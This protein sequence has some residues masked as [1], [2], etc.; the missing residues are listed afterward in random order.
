M[1]T[2]TYRCRCACYWNRCT[3]SPRHCKP[4]SCP[5]PAHDRLHMRAHAPQVKRGVEER[6]QEIAT[7]EKVASEA[8][9]VLQK[10]FRT[11]LEAKVTRVYTSSVLYACADLPTEWCACRRF[12]WRRASVLRS[13]LCKTKCVDPKVMHPLRIRS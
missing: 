1:L 5:S 4:R 6:L 12:H 13:R 2:H 10:E 3:R 11:S 7:H 8:R 9:M